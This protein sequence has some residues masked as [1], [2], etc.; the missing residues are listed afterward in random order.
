MVREEDRKTFTTEDTE[1]L[2]VIKKEKN[3]ENSEKKVFLYIFTEL[4]LSKYI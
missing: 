2:I 4:I 1:K 3:T